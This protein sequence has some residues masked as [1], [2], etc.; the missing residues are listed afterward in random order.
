MKIVTE[1]FRQSASECGRKAAMEFVERRW[2]AFALPL[3]AALI[4]AMWDWRWIVAAMALVLVAYPFALMMAY[5]S[6]MLTPEGAMA[7]LRRR[8]EIGDEGIDIVYEPLDDEH[9]E[10]DARHIAISEVKGYEDRGDSIA[11]IHSGGTL[12]IPVSAL[13][14]QSAADLVAFLSGLA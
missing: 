6:R 3:A 1:S 5:Y 12:V 9:P 10:P 8:V 11:V 7:L 2:W 13:D 4:A 14:K